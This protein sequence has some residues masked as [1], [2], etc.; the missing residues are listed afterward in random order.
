MLLRILE[1]LDGPT[2]GMSQPQVS[3]LFSG[4]SLGLANT[5]EL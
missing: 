2:V 1:C 4:A 3:V 5:I